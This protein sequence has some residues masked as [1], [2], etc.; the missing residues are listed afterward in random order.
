ME[1]EKLIDKKRFT[2]ITKKFEKL[3]PIAVIGDIGIDKYTIGEVDRISP[4]APVP[5]LHVKEEFHKL[6]MAANISH[7]LK[8]LGVNSTLYG[9]LGKDTNSSVF[10]HL[11]ETEELPTDGLLQ[12]ENRSTIFKERVT[13]PMQQLCRV[14]YETIEDLTPFQEEKLLEKL[15]K[16]VGKHA[17]LIIE[18]YGKGTLTESVVERS[19]KIFQEAGKIVAVDP[20]RVAHPEIYK[21]VNL[22]KPNQVE[23]KLMVEALGYRGNSIEEMAE[24]L[25]DKLNL[26]MLVITLGKDGMFFYDKKN[27]GQMGQIPTLANEVF[28]VSGAGD[29]T[30]SLIIAALSCGATLSESCWIGN[31]G[32]GVVV[33][34]RGTAT[35]GMQELHRFYHRL[36]EDWSEVTAQ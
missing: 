18:D 35:V 12:C 9:A 33:A 20:S 10:H 16:N 23:S 2:E 3:N 26:E 5:V 15:G 29:T 14:D 7:N 36:Q 13:T 11:L 1:M 17:S 34:K 19:I 24:I 27:G 6:A 4:E 25:V 31:C 32:A 28:D 8:A 30:I 22:L 21:N